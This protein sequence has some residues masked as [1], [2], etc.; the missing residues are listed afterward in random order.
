[1]VKLR[2]RSLLA[3]VAREPANPLDRVEQL[4]ALLLDEHRSQQVA[5]QP[6]VAAERAGA[7][8]GLGH[9]CR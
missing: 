5:E 8:A 2:D 3:R 9:W 6:N 4:S 7:I 1:L